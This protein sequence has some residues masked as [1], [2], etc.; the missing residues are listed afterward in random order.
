MAKRA[1]VRAVPTFGSER[2]EREYWETH[3]SGEVVDW[4]NARQVVFP[5]LKASTETIS[6]RLPTAL[7]SDLKAQL[8][9]LGIAAEREGNYADDKRA[10]IKVIAGSLHLPIEI[11]CEWNDHLWKAIR[12]QL[13]AKYGRESVSD[14]YGIYLVFWFTGAHMPVAGDGLAKPK[15]PQELQQRLAATVPPELKHKIAVLVVDCS[16]R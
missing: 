8:E 4:P 14:G 9:P 11:K 2:A 15:T 13:V 1:I 12:E 16:K 7:L 6:L 10:D 5:N 3:D